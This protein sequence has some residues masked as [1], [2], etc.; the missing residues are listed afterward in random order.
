MGMFT[1]KRN[2]DGNLL[3]ANCVLSVTPFRGV[4]YLHIKDIIKGKSVS[5]SLPEFEKLCEIRNVLNNICEESL[6]VSFI[7]YTFLIKHMIIM[8]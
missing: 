2:E 1:Y 5:L 6:A 7:L 3:Y 4:A 8:M